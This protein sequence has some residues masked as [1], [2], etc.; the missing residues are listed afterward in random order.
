MFCVVAV[1]K[2]DIDMTPRHLQHHWSTAQL[3]R[4]CGPSKVKLQA[5]NSRSVHVTFVG[6]ILF[7][8]QIHETLL[9]VVKEIENIQVSSL[10][11]WK[12]SFAFEEYL[13]KANNNNYG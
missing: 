5:G 8:M 13:H 2:S 7:A 10:T 11:S 3:L 9:L 6:S 1:R 4:C 12:A